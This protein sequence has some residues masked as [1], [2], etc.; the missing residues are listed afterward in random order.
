MFNNKRFLITQPMIRGFNGSTLVTLELATTLQKLGAKVTIYTCD[1]AKPAAP[2]FQKANL[3]V[4]TITDE[5]NYKLTDFDYIWIH[6]QILPISIVKQLT[7]AKLPK[8]LP[9]FIFLHM[10]G[11]DWIPD[12]KPWIFNLENTLSSLSVFISEEVLDINKPLLNPNIPTAFFRNPAPEEY[13]KIKTNPSQTLKKLLIVSNHPPK[14]VLEAKKILI[15]NHGIEVSVLGE[16]QDKYTL[17]N[18][19]IIKKYDAVLTIAKTVPYCLLTNTP[20]YVYDVY[21][22]GPGWL[23]DKNFEDAKY[24]NFS[25]Y[26]NHFFPN[27]EG[28]GFSFKTASQIVKELL[29]GYSDALSFQ[30]NHHQEFVNEFS[31][32]KVLP[33]LL[34]KTSPRSI[35]PFS[36][37]YSESVIASQLFAANRFEATALLYE[38]DKTIHELYEQ[39]WDLEGK[40]KDL[41]HYKASTEAVISSPLFRTSNTIIKPYRKIKAKLKRNH[42]E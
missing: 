22:G 7:G 28:K 40:L 1:L 14:E 18:P 30:T 29:N 24:R 34:K 13:L 3:K 21:G 11:M 37:D 38:R 23:N 19:S 35:L 15:E 17:I 20:V 36:N 41:E 42:H 31:L 33:I 26:K 16:G 25:G 12:E 8:H 4:D 5:P 10:S 6:S 32:E 39:I 9:S 27:H 2:H